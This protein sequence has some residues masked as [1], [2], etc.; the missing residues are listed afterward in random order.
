M[1]DKYEVPERTTCPVDFTVFQRMYAPK[2]DLSAE[3]LKEQKFSCVKEAYLVL[4]QM[5]RSFVPNLA[6][7]MDKDHEGRVAHSI[8]FCCSTVNHRVKKQEGC[9]EWNA[10]L[11]MQSD[12]CYCFT[13]ISSFS[14]HRE[15]CIK[16]RARFTSMEV[17]F[18][19][20]F[21]R[22]S[23]SIVAKILKQVPVDET[24]MTMRKT[25]QASFL[26][27]SDRILLTNVVKG[28]EP[29][30]NVSSIPIEEVGNKKEPNEA[31]RLLQFLTHIEQHDSACAKA[32]FGRDE[33]GRLCLSMMTFIWPE[34]RCLLGSR[35]DAIFCDSMWHIN[36]DGDYILTI[37]VVNKEEKLRLAASAIAF[38]E[39]K[40][41]W[42][43]FFRWVKECV[44]DFDPQCIV[45]DG[46]DY[47]H[48]AF[49]KA[50]KRKVLHAS[51]WWHRNKTVKRMFGDIGAIAKSL[52]SM[53]YA[54]SVDELVKKEE[55]AMQK[56]EQL[57]EV[58]TRN[59]SVKKSELATLSQ[60]LNEIGEHSFITLPVF[61]GG[62]LSNSYAES[63]NSCLRKIGLTAFNSR[64]A[65][66][67]A[68]RNYCKAAAPSRKGYSADRRVLLGRMMQSD[69]LEVVSDGVL[70]HQAKQIEQ[71]M[72]KHSIDKCKIL[73]ENE[74]SSE[75][76][77]QETIEKKLRKDLIIR[78]Q[79]ERIVTWIREPDTPDK[80]TC[81]CNALVYR[82]MPCMHIALV[83]V[84]H[85][86]KIPLQCF[87]ERYQYLNSSGG[88]LTE[89]VQGSS[90]PPPEE[91]PLSPDETTDKIEFIPGPELHITESFLNARFGD[92]ESI[93]I[94]GEL[95][96]L[97]LMILGEFKPR[98]SLKEV[99]DS[100][101]AIRTSLQTKIDELNSG[102]D[103]SHVVVPHAKRRVGKS[104]YKTGPMKVAEACAEAMK[105]N[106][107]STSSQSPPAKKPF[108]DQQ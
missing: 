60:T 22:H 13:K 99:L 27:E 106:N 94:R 35:S 107:P 16:E 42:E 79:A 74:E 28:L 4:S 59:A 86:Y 84:T 29:D 104:S 20:L 50:V 80:V 61:T 19:Q 87:H 68:L 47:I 73:R 82:G 67:F 9:C 36:E 43:W 100:I 21:P 3:K 40:Q 102:R 52:Q 65:S 66:M 7:H 14:I 70:R 31:Y 56:L 63:I 1:V 101:Q 32:F 23:R 81:S 88:E 53:V 41:H 83:A 96:S 12:G 6:V 57:K 92:E 55:D 78:R 97:E 38:R 93:R 77:V 54:D 26:T 24:T 69:V 11:V 39:N 34:G 105:R 37:V 18:Q 58:G 30:P 48:T 44:N 45:T 17:D 98:A 76:V 10:K 64:L 15:K 72:K 90:P 75:F 8:S 49:I 103:E 85:G 5:I 33:K 25:R 62:T 51:C 108:I 71:T 46:A 95:R 89:S 2:M 91:E